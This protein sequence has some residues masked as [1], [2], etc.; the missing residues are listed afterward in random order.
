MEKFQTPKFVVFYL[1]FSFFMIF[2]A[3][4]VLVWNDARIDWVEL[5]SMITASAE[6]MYKFSAQ[7]EGLIP[8]KEQAALIKIMAVIPIPM[9]A[10]FAYDILS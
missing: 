3:W 1:I 10:K 6:D 5:S 8:E 2:A 4:G 7:R 9:L